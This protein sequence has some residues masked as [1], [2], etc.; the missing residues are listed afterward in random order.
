MRSVCKRTY[1]PFPLVPTRFVFVFDGLLRRRVHPRAGQKRCSTRQDGEDSLA[2]IRLQPLRCQPSLHASSAAPSLPAVTT[3]MP[4]LSVL[5][6][7]VRFCLQSDD[8]TP[9]TIRPPRKKVHPSP[10]A[11]TTRM[12]LL[13]RCT[14]QSTQNA[15][16]DRVSADNQKCIE[17]MGPNI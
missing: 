17:D 14:G 16:V 8:N 13:L 7:R 15:I 10:P 1:V 4:C 5:S 12:P 2:T 3:R 11:L 6:K 9:R